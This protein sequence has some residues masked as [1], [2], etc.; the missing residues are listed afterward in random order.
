MMSSASRAHQRFRAS[1][2]CLIREVISYCEDGR[3]QVNP[4]TKETISS[5][6]FSE[7][8]SSDA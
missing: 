5:P 4:K 6:N 7:K 3:H 8:L 2:C 1:L